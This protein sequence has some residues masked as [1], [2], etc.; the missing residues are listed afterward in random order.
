MQSKQL[1]RESRI[2]QVIQMMAIPGK[3]GEEK[4]IANYITNQLIRAGADRRSIKTD[5]AHRRTV[6]K[7]NCG[8]LIFK[9]PG[10]YRAPRRMLSAHMDTVPICVGC[11]PVR[12]GMM[13]TSKDPAT[14]LGA[15]N[16]AG[17]G[18]ILSA[19]QE[20]LKNKLPRSDL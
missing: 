10:T 20:I 13:V 1:K 9:M 2:R 15:D 6:I 12:K 8:N 11:Q 7:G 4:E 17:C 3:S 19:S 18:V 16:R 14:G 5:T